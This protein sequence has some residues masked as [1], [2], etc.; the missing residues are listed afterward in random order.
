MPVKPDNRA[1][2]TEYLDTKGHIYI[3]AA[4]K[5]GCTVAHLGDLAFVKLLQRLGANLTAESSS[6]QTPLE[7]AS[8]A[9]YKDFVAWLTACISA[10]DEPTYRGR[11][12][13]EDRY[14][15]KGQSAES[16]II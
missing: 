3:I 14:G 5:D 15:P 13:V 10:P 6:G 4:G 7:M 16:R 2:T 12:R 8:N 9:G 1:E 11:P